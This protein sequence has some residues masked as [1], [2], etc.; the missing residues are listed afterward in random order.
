MAPPFVPTPQQLNQWADDVFAAKERGAAINLGAYAGNVGV[1]VADFQDA[2]RRQYMQWGI[3]AE[4]PWA[5]V[6]VTHEFGQPLVLALGLDVL[7]GPAM[8]RTIKEEEARMGIQSVAK[9]QVVAFAKELDR[10]ATAFAAQA[11]VAL[12]MMAANAGRACQAAGVAVAHGAVQAAHAMAQGAAHVAQAAVAAA[13]EISDAVADRIANYRARRLARQSARADQD[14]LEMQLCE[15]LLGR[16]AVEEALTYQLDIAGAENMQ[17]AML[18][19][20]GPVSGPSGAR[21]GA[22][23]V[24]PPPFKPVAVPV[25]GPIVLMAPPPIAFATHPL[26]PRGYT[27]YED[28]SGNCTTAVREIY[29]DYVHQLSE[30]DCAIEVPDRWFLLKCAPT[31]DGVLRMFLRDTGTA[32]RMVVVTRGGYSEAWDV[33]AGPKEINEPFFGK[34]SLKVPPCCQLTDCVVHVTYPHVIPSAAIGHVSL[35]LPATYTFG[36][37]FNHW[38]LFVETSISRLIHNCYSHGASVTAAQ[39]HGLQLRS[40]PGSRL[41][42]LP[43]TGVLRIRRPLVHCFDFN[44]SMWRFS[45]EVA[46]CREHLNLCRVAVGRDGPVVPSSMLRRP[47]HHPSS[48]FDPF[49][50]A[51]NEA[52]ECVCTRGVERPVQ[53]AAG[54]GRITIGPIT[55]LEG[56][57]DRLTAPEDVAI[58]NAVINAAHAAARMEYGSILNCEADMTVFARRA[59]GK[60]FYDYVAAKMTSTP[61]PRDKVMQWMALGFTTNIATAILGTGL[62]GITVDTGTRPRCYCGAKAMNFRSMC[63]KCASRPRCTICRQWIHDDVGCSEHGVVIGCGSGR[64]Y[65]KAPHPTVAA[66]CRAYKACDDL[67]EA[68]RPAMR[69][70]PSTIPLPHF[71]LPVVAGMGKEAAPRDPAFTWR[72]EPC[73]EFKT[74]KGAVA[75]GLFVS[76]FPPMVYSPTLASNARAITARAATEPLPTYTL[77]EQAQFEQVMQYLCER[78]LPPNRLYVPECGTKRFTGLFKEA[79]HHFDPTKRKYYWIVYTKVRAGEM[80]WRDFAVRTFP[81]YEKKGGY[82]ECQSVAGR[83]ADTTALAIW[84]AVQNLTFEDDLQCPASVLSTHRIISDFHTMVDACVNLVLVHCYT[85]W[86]KKWWNPHNEDDLASRLLYAG[87]MD[88]LEAAAALTAWRDKWGFSWIQETDFSKFDSR[89]RGVVYTLAR[90]MLNR[91]HPAAFL[92]PLTGASLRHRMDPN[93]RCQLVVPGPDGSPQMKV[94]GPV[95]QRSGDNWT[96]AL[97]TT[98]ALILTVYCTLLAATLL[99]VATFTV[100]QAE[101][102]LSRINWGAVGCGD[103]QFRG[104]DDVATLESTNDHMNRVNMTCTSKPPVPAHQWSKVTMLGSR[105]VRVKYA[106]K[107]VPCLVPDLVRFVESR[108]W[109]LHHTLREDEWVYGVSVQDIP[110]LGDMPIQRVFVKHNL[111][112]SERSLAERMPTKTFRRYL[113]IRREATNKRSANDILGDPVAMDRLSELLD[114][115]WVHKPWKFIGARGLCEACDETWTDLADAYTGGDVAVLRRLD[116]TLDAE[117]SMVRTLPCA[118]VNWELEKA[119]ANAAGR[120]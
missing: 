66:Y 10:R 89:Q 94:S 109:M 63:S 53:I 59:Q 30:K 43:V 86:L 73:N 106:G 104:A 26:V 72:D 71:V 36:H 112:L 9:Q 51:E 75:S 4:L 17:E 55:G 7:A 68:L 44:V 29:R 100:A 15:P 96:A 60:E 79:C 38:S 48:W 83:P 57:A 24:A 28:T 76:K 70:S 77:A 95:F 52:L 47:E 93:G 82:W 67:N 64:R 32:P 19:D 31:L 21:L 49:P 111:R 120:V 61:R 119:L 98:V 85:K 1:A 12:P 2:V 62:A 99:T 20:V 78:L 14:M 80:A 34:G 87:G 37:R 108:S 97:G 91:I 40:I 56:I 117:F 6:D 54:G 39:A 46:T 65:L 27:L 110:I 113:N 84:K 101:A 103:D 45:H 118:V 42:P 16:S 25:I 13:D 50:V 11:A 114:T 22:V 88:S 116:A 23:R 3:M 5:P 115:D 8:W 18:L 92:H 69:C 81:K 58:P 74:R 35:W 105:I 33:V 41:S 107:V 102:A 90:V